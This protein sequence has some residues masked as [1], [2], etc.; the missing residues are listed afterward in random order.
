MSGQSY[1]FLM[2]GTIFILAI[3]CAGCVSTNVGDASY[4]NGSVMVRITNT[5]DP[6][7]VTIQVTAY[8]IQDL[9]QQM[10]TIAGAP[11]TIPAGETVVTVPVE[12]EPGTYKLYIYVLRD[13]D[14]KNA[15]IRDITV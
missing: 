14:R 3:L 12:L 1:R 10:Y 6:I 2:A 5:G 9:H 4:S 15:V 8:R 11:V 7:P 13:G